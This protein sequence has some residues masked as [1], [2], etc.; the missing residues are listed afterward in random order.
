M[1]R[2]LKICGRIKDPDQAKREGASIT[3]PTAEESRTKFL[4]TIAVDDPDREKRVAAYDSLQKRNRFCEDMN[5]VEVQLKDWRALLEDA[6]AGGNTNARLDLANDDIGEQYREHLK[7]GSY[8]ANITPSQVDAI[9]A[10]IASGDPY[11][12]TEGVNLLAGSY[13][14]MSLRD[15]TGQA[16]DTKALIVAGRL[17]SCDAGYLCGENS[18]DLIQGCALF[19][20]CGA[21]NYRDYTMYYSA[22]PYA[23]QRVAQYEQALRVA[24]TSNDWSGFRFHPGPATLGGAMLW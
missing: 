4:D 21:T 9:K 13:A 12:I 16:I 5:G 2:L 1:A 18:P 23:S 7:A 15:S 6:A 14:N 10:A 11:G 17:M 19:D 22:S 20:Q 24:A 8:F 3:V